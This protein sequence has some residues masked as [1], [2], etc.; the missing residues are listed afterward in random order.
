MKW[1][2]KHLKESKLRLEKV[3]TKPMAVG[4]FINVTSV[5]HLT[6][7]FMTAHTCKQYGNV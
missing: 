5:I 4:L 2:P 3:Q 6:I 1:V 7:G